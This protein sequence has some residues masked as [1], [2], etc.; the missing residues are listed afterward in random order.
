MTTRSLAGGW[1]QKSPEVRLKSCKSTV[2]YKHS[3]P[4]LS[5]LKS[6]YSTS[7]ARSGVSWLGSSNDVGNPVDLST[8]LP[9]QTGEVEK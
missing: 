9:V 5:Q 7:V 6:E 3:K 4:E 2:V 1:K 8:V